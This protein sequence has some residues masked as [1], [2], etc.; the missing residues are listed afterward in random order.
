MLAMMLIGLINVGALLLSGLV[1]DKGLGIHIGR[2]Q[3]VKFGKVERRAD[4]VRFGTSTNESKAGNAVIERAS[5]IG[6]GKEMQ[7]DSAAC[8]SVV[9]RV[10]AVTDASA[11]QSGNTL[12]TNLSRGYW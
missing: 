4:D 12:E 3:V 8:E 1:A 6:N 10:S 7:S 11:T 5:A 9:G 2:G